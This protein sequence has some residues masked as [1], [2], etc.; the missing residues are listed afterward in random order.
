MNH[1]IRQQIQF[2]DWATSTH[3]MT[4]LCLSLLVIFLCSCQQS[5]VKPTD[6]PPPSPPP[7]SAP[8]E[9][10]IELEEPPV[11]ETQKLEW[12]AKVAL[13][14]RAEKSKQ[15][16]EAARYYNEALDLIDNPT[17]TPQAPSPAEIKKVYEQATK[18]QL[19]ADTLTPLP[20][21]RLSL[22]NTKC[23]STMRAR[24]RGIS[25]TK[26]LKAVQFEFDQTTFTTIGK[27]A[28]Q[29]LSACLKER[30]F[31]N[32][33]QVTLIGHTDEKGTREYNQDLSERRAN[34]LKNY[35]I[36]QAITAKIST[37]GRGEDEPVHL[38]N[39]EDFTQEEIDALNRRVEIITE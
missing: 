5:A 38:D 10:A 16:R 24:V 29:Q 3:K 18:A 28:A 11:S 19:I 8:D 37:Q 6:S 39:P 26:H 4:K 34:A 13:G 27:Q 2:S 7:A 17:A 23:S 20:P 31:S 1:V 9:S 21:I 32:I 25:M 22:Q 36:L 14:K 15:W 33:S 12:K 35:I 30:G